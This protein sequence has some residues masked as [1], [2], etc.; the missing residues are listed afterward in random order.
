MHFKFYKSFLY[1]FSIKEILKI[2]T[3]ELVNRCKDLNEKIEHNYKV[4]HESE[5]I[6]MSDVFRDEGITKSDLEVLEIFKKDQ[7]KYVLDIR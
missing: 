1:F 5:R 3:L 6:D 7:E 4:L 2:P